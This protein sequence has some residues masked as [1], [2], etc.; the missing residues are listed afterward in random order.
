MDACSAVYG[1]QSE[2]KD[3]LARLTDEDC[4]MDEGMP[5]E[6]M[7]ETG[8]ASLPGVIQVIKKTKARRARPM[9][10]LDDHIRKAQDAIKQ[11]RKQV[12]TARMQAK[13][14]KRKKTRLMRKA[15]SLNI[16]DLERIAVLKRCG[17]IQAAAAP[18]SEECAAGAPAA[19]TTA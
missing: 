1:I 14:E 9:I 6:P 18:H 10:D 4:Q 15:S 17:L 3:M 2:Q 12:Q 13:L 19:S 8:Q 11:A 7:H 5:G 16:E